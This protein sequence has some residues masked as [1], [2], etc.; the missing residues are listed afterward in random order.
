MSDMLD[1][2]TLYHD[3]QHKH[4]LRCMKC[5]RIFKEGEPYMS[6]VEKRRKDG[7]V[8]RCVY[9]LKCKGRKVKR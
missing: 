8:V 3:R 4:G 6:V 5:D 7:I 2:V 9:C 1:E